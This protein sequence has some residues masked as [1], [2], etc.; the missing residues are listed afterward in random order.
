MSKLKRFSIKPKKNK[1]KKN[2]KKKNI[3]IHKNKK[4]GSNNK[5]KK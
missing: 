3:L 2:T 5:E 1:L 4:N